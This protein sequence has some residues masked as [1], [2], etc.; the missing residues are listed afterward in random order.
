MTNIVGVRFRQ[1]GKIYYFDPL[2]WQF[3]LNEPV[4]VE[5]ARG[6]E[7]GQVALEN[8]EVPESEITAPLKAII[9]KANPA[10]LEQYEKNLTDEEQAMATCKDR[11]RKHKL[12]MKPVDVEYTLDRNKIIF[13]FTAEGRVDF[14]ELV[15]DLASVFRTRIELRQ[16]GVRDEAKMRN[17]IGPC[18]R[19]LC[20]ATHLQDFTSVSIRMAKEQSLSLNPSKISGICGRLMCCLKYEQDNYEYVRRILPKVGSRVRTPDGE[21]DVI[22]NS[23]IKRQLR[24]KVNINDE[25]IILYHSI[26]DCEL[27]SG[28]YE[29]SG[30][31][32]HSKEEESGG[33]KMR[34]NKKEVQKILETED[35]LKG[36]GPDLDATTQEITPPGT[37]E[38]V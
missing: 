31:K 6:I 29:D 3:E 5:T 26:D 25:D 13:Y 19:E 27:L 18:G 14:R 37:E 32:N 38:E 28:S 30:K 24:V 23:A 8:K 16:I 36:N 10:D 12:E 4:V 34:R 15:K 35:C 22:G 1:A 20:C 17:G 21:G 7:I 11:I 33:K 2:E 9:R